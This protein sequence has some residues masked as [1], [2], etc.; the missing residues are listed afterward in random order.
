MNTKKMEVMRLAED[1]KDTGA[2]SVGATS[3]KDMCDF[4]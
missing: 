3:L 4:R 1:G 2:F